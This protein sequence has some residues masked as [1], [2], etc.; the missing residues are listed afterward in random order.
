MVLSLTRP[1]GLRDLFMKRA[2]MYAMTVHRTPVRMPTYRIGS[3]HEYCSVKSPEY[4]VKESE[5]MIRHTRKIGPGV[6]YMGDRIPATAATAH[7][8]IMS[9]FNTL[10]SMEATSKK[11]SSPQSRGFQS[12]KVSE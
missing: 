10:P 1:S 6:L 9:R 11:E 4:T 12:S 3:T 7:R 2:E 8:A 5:I